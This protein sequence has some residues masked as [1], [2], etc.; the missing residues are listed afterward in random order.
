MNGNLSEQE[1]RFLG[2]ARQALL[3]S[4]DRLDAA[5]LARLREARAKAVEAAGEPARGFFRVPN[6]MRAGAFATAA[7]AV[8]VFAVWVDPPK[9]ELPVKSVDEFEI[10]LYADNLELYEDLDFYEWLA[11]VG[12]GGSST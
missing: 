6:W 12:N 1:T 4:E 2:K 11:D 8:I 5:T 3:A 10:V 9:Q 7:A